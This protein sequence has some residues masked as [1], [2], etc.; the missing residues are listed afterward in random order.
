MEYIEAGERF[1][2]NAAGSILTGINNAI[3]ET[4]R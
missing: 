3:K 4:I 2:E 1:V